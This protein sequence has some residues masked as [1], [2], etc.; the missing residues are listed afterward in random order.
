MNE[1]LDNMETICQF[2]NTEENIP[3]SH[4]TEEQLGNHTLIYLGMIQ[5]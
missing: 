1:L 2:T 4:N 3:Q 5:D